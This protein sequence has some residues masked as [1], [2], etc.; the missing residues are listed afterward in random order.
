MSQILTVA[1]VR[2]GSL[3]YFFPSKEHVLRAVLETYLDLLEPN[4]L[5]PAF[6]RAADPLERLFAVLD[7]Y[8]QLLQASNF[9]LGCPIGNLAL[10]LSASHPQARPLIAENFE[11]WSIAITALIESFA[12]R[13]PR[14]VRPATLAR[15]VQATMEG[16]IVLARAYHSVE[17]F[18]Q[19]MHQLRD[20]L[21]RLLRDG[22]IQCGPGD[23]AAEQP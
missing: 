7:G 18:D 10:E 15:H 19:A 12:D 16:A 21:E 23:R 1:D 14:D 9:E 11:A 13:L 2:S 3:Y 6:E 20:Y 22:A 4:I 5:R 8:R 17:P